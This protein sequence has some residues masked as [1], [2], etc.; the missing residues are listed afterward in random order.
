MPLAIDPHAR[1]SPFI[2]HGGLVLLVLHVLVSPYG[3]S[4]PVAALAILLQTVFYVLLVMILVGSGSRARQTLA[5]FALIVASTVVR[6]VYPAGH[7]IAQA[8][9]DLALV[10]VGVFVLAVATQRILVTRAVTPALISASIS[11][12]LL[13]GIVWAIAFHAVES[14]HSGS[15]AVPAGHE[16]PTPGALYY[17]SFVTLTTL[18]YGD[19]SPS[20]GFARSL[21]MLEA[22]FGQVFLVVLL[23]RVVSLQVAP[24]GPSARF[25]ASSELREAQA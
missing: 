20:T 18:G 22:V 14:L 12:Y 25:E 11:V 15:F 17:L 4:D 23:G 7:G 2:G 1:L 9:A 10:A 21:A 13:A 3:L 16:D 6:I 5:C 8:F 24:R 19:V